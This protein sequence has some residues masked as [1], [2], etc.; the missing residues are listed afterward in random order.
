MAG[1]LRQT[2]RNIA[3]VVFPAVT[4]IAGPPAAALGKLW[5]RFGVRPL[6]DAELAV[7][8]CAGPQSHLLMFQI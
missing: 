8:P 4:R 5:I 7:I 6:G 2:R 1:V 3:E